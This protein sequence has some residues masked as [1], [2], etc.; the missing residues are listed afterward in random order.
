MSSVN[1]NTATTTTTAPRDDTPTTTSPLQVHIDAT[2]ERVVRSNAVDFANRVIDKLATHYNLNSDEMKDVAGLGEVQVKRITTKRKASGSASGSG[3]G[4]ESGSSTKWEKP[5]V[6]LPWTGKRYD[7]PD[8]C[9][10]IRKSYGLFS[11]CVM[12]RVGEGKYCKTCGN[13]A[14]KNASKKPNFGDVEDR[15]ADT[16]TD[17]DGVVRYTVPS[18]DKN[19]PVKNYANVIDSDILQL[20]RKNEAKPEKKAM[21]TRENV[22]A[23]ASKFGLEIP[24]EYWT[25]VESKRG[26]K[27]KSTS[28][29]GTESA[30][31]TM[32]ENA[33]YAEPSD[34]EF[35]KVMKELEEDEA[36]EAEAK[37]K[38]TTLT[39]TTETTEPTEPTE[40]TLTETMGYDDDVVSAEETKSETKPK[41][42]KPKVKAK[43]KSKSTSKFLIGG[44]VVK[45]SK[46]GLTIQLHKDAR[47]KDETNKAIGD[48]SLTLDNSQ[49]TVKDETVMDEEGNAYTENDLVDLLYADK[50]G[51]DEESDDDD[52]EHDDE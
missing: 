13:Q 4:S 33:K 42:K 37:A 20:G 17:E 41:S 49:L 16:F 38:T 3:S 18:T 5:T 24:E 47:D 46:A 22:E 36:E 32:V 21:Y 8:T 45:N 29:S 30:D 10:G 52:D 35:D 15:E 48:H 26:R 14:D 12:K 7:N 34:E 9:L 44:V 19:E 50:H 11:Q 25:K 6:I 31:G 39:E 1:A 40:P 23:E 43:S 27:A 28:G 51:M 2:L